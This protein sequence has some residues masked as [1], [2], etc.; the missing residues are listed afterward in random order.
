MFRVFGHFKK[1]GLNHRHLYLFSLVLLL[2][3]IA[4]GMIVFFLPILAKEH[5]E[6]MIIVGLV[7]AS[8][9]FWDIVAD[10]FLGMRSKPIKYQVLTR[11][12]FFLIFA[13]IAVNLLP[14]GHNFY[15]SLGVLLLSMVLWG[16]HY[17]AM[18]LGSYNFVVVHTDKPEQASSFGVIFA[19]RSLGYTIGPIIAGLA[20]L[21]GNNLVLAIAAFFIILGFIFFNLKC[22][23]GF[24]KAAAEAATRKM[25]LRTEFKIWRRI[26][27]KIFPILLVTFSLGVFAGVVTSMT[28]I[29]VETKENFSL[30]GGFIVAA[31]SVP[32]IIF[33]G[34]FGSLADHHGKRQFILLGGLLIILTMSVFGAV[35]SPWLAMIL[36]FLAGTGVSLLFPSTEALYS[37]YI[38]DHAG[39]EEE[40]LGEMGV[41]SNLGFILGAALG[42]IS[43]A[44]TGSFWTAYLLVSIFFIISL[45]CFSLAKKTSLSI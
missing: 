43:V 30:W 37:N 31:F 35:G 21:Q 10:L 20:I 11:V 18:L 41:A 42:G 9:S 7:L 40:T 2:Y 33:G 14:T 23:D 27:R 8:S 38:E 19:F 15:F 1:H 4:D 22:K 36:A 28:P 26:G 16:F 24:P 45:T 32:L 6:S 44:L 12:A 3:T 17:E 5:L 13:L 29:L 34:W 25:R 39:D